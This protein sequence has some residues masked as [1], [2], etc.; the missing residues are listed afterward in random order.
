MILP[1]HLSELK[2]LRQW[3]NYVR[4]WNA[5]KHGGQG[6]YDKPPIN[7][8]T[9][10]D[11][12]TNDPTTWAIYD[13]AEA[14]VGKSATHKDSKHKDSTGTAPIITA[15]IEGTGLVLANGYCGVD[16]DDVIDEAGNVAPWAAA[17]IER[18]D[19][20]TEISPS[21]H[22]LHSLLCCGNL[23]AAGVDF[24][25]QFLIDADGNVTTDPTQ[26]RSELEIYFYTRGGRYFTITGNVYRDRPIA[27]DKDDVLKAIYAEHMAKLAACKAALR[28]ARSVGSLRQITRPASSDAERKML[29]SALAAID[30]FALDFSE[31]SAVMTALRI[32]GFTLSEAEAWSSGSLGGYVN[33]KNVPSTNA[34]RWYRFTYKR[35][36]EN[37]AG[38]I[39]NEAKRQGWT[40]ADAFD[41][42]ERREYGRTL[43]T[44]DERREYGRQQHEARLDK[45]W[46]EHEDGFREWKNRRKTKQDPQPQ[47]D[48]TDDF[49]AWKK[50]RADK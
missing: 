12:R 33:S 32:C 28:P 8:H 46:S 6:G 24:G 21:G 50:G 45:F 3:V 11:G 17:I 43:Y 38:T 2:P 36:D 22:G 18:L 49:R 13:E 25:K 15:P 47:Y 31:W 27:R 35:S 10:R 14:N 9:L 41:D 16:F 42:E 26:K 34:R 44:E 29:D 40:P 48:F 20:Y 7:P 30:P 37:A 23:L 5:D 1:Q 4:I 39:I 19:T